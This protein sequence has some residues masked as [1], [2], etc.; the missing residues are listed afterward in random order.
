M[1]KNQ[2]Y[3]ANYK[4]GFSKKISVAAKFLAFLGLFVGALY[5]NNLAAQITVVNSQTA[6]GTNNVVITRPT[7]LQV[8]DLM[9]VNLQYTPNNTLT[10]PSGWTERV[11]YEGGSGSTRARI[12]YKVAI[13]ADV[14]ATNYTFSV[15]SGVRIAGG[16]SA[17]RGVNTA[18]DGG[19]NVLGTEVFANNSTTTIQPPA[20]T[21]TAANSMVLFFSQLR[22]QNLS[23]NADWK[24]GGASGTA[25]NQLYVQ[26]A[27]NNTDGCGVSGAFFIRP[28]TGSTGA[29][30]QTTASGDGRRAGILMALT[31]IPASSALAGVSIPSNSFCA[32]TTKQPLHAFSLAQTVGNG[33][34]SEVSFSTTGTYL[35][36][37]VVNFKLWTNTT[38]NLTSAVQ[39][40]STLTTSLGSGTHTFSGFTQTLTVNDTRFFWITTDA[41]FPTSNKTIGVSAITTANLTI[42]GSKT[43][44]P[45]TATSRTLNSTAIISGAISPVTIPGGNNGAIDVSLTG[46][47][48]SFSYSWSNGAASQD[49]S[50]LT[51]GNY[52]LTLT[53]GNNCAIARTFIVGTNLV[54][55]QLYLSDPSQSLD[56]VSPINTF[57]NTTASSSVFSTISSGSVTITSSKVSQNYQSQP[58]RNFGNTTVA[59]VEAENN[60][61]SRTFIQFDLSNIPSGATITSAQLKLVHTNVASCDNFVGSGAAFTTNVQRVTREWDE[62]DQ[63]NATT[64]N[65]LSWNTAGSTNWSDPGGDFHPT[66][67]ASWVGGNADAEGTEY[68]M[69]ITT[70]VNEWRN[71]THPNY[72]L[73]LVS[74]S[75]GAGGRWYNIFADEASVEANRPQL[76]VSY[77]LPSST[78]TSFTQS[79]ALASPLTIKAGNPISITNYVTVTG[80]SM[81]SNPSITAT[82]RYGSTTIATLTNPTYNSSTG[83]LT[84]TTTL[85]SDVTVPA[86]QAISLDITTAQSG[87]AFII[88][89]DSQAKPSLIDLPVSSY[90]NI[91]SLD[92]YNAANPGGS[93]ITSANGASTVYLRSNVTDPFGFADITGMDISIT[94]PGGA[95]SSVTGTS[96]AGSGAN[97]TYEY[98]WTT[99]TIGGA[100]TI[101]AIAKE[102]F[103]NSVIA[104]RQTIFNICDP[105]LGGNVSTQT[106]ILC[107]G[108]SSGSFT[109]TGS[110]GTPPYQYSLNS[111]AF[112]TTNTFTGRPAGSYTVA[113]RDANN[114]TSSS[115][116]NITLS[117]PAAAVTVTPSIT[118]PT[119][120]AFG[121]I[122]LVAAGGTAPY[123]YD[124]AD[125]SGT[126]NP[127][128]RTGLAAG[129][130]TVVV[131][132]A[133]GCTVSSGSITLDP[134]VGCAPITI[135]TNSSS[136]SVFSVDPDPS[137]TNYTWTITPA[138][139]V[140]TGQGT[141]QI[142]VN[143]SGVTTAG[144]FQVCV[145]AA[146]ACGTTA[147]LCQNVNVVLPPVPVVSAGPAC[148]GQN[149]QLLASGG[150]SYVWSGPGGFASSVANPI[151]AN[152]S[153]SNNGT[154]SVLIT[155]AAGCSATGTV[156]VTV[157][158]PPVLSAAVTNSTACASTSGAVNLTVTP[159]GTYSYVWNNGASNFS[160]N[161]DVTGLV[162]GNYHVLVTNTTSGCTAPA[163]Y[164]V[165]AVPGPMPTGIPVNIACFGTNAGAI[166]SIG[167]MGGTA[168]YAFSWT[169]PNGFTSASTGTSLTGLAAGTYNLTVIDNSGCTGFFTTTI[170]QASAINI[171]FSQTNVSCFGQATGSISVGAAGGTG[172]YSYGWLRNGS[173]FGTN[174]ATLGSL[175][176][177][178]YQVTVSDGNGCTASQIIEITQPAAA[179]GAVT[180][181]TNVGCFGGTNGQVVLSPT[182]GTAPY[183]F[184]WTGPSGFTAASKDI[185]GRAAGTY[186]V[187]ITDARGCTFVVSGIIITQSSAITLATVT[188]TPVSC[189]GGSNGVIEVLPSGGTAPFGYQWS[190]G[191][192]TAR[193]TGLLAGS[194]TVTVTDA[195]G[196]QPAFA[197]AIVVGQPAAAL[198]VTATPAAVSCFGGTNGGVTTVV[199]GGTTD[200]AYFWSNN[201]ATP[202][203]SNVVAGNYQVTV[204]DN[205][206]CTAIATATVGSPADI[207][208]S[209]VITDVLCNGATTGTITLSVTGGTPNFSYNWG[210]GIM[211]Q[212][213]TDLGAGTYEVTVT[214]GNG[215]T[216]TKAYTITEASLLAAS[217][218]NTNISCNGGSNGA[219]NLSVSGGVGPYTYL[220]SNGANTEDLIGLAAGP[221]SVTVT[222]ANNCSAVF[223]APDVI[224][225]AV[226]TLSVVADKATDCFGGTDGGATATPTGGTA[227][228]TYQWSDGGS[229]AARIDL[230][231]GDYTVTVTDV[232][233]CTAQNTVIISQPTELE[234]F[235]EV[236][237]NNGC[238]Q[239][240]SGAIVLTVQGGT[241]A[242]SY[243]WSRTGGGFSSSF[244]DISGLSAGTYTVTVTDGNGCARQLTSVVGTEVSTLSASISKTDIT[245]LGFPNNTNGT[246]SVVAINGTLPYAYDWTGTPIGDGTASISSLAAGTY[247]VTI[248]DAGGCTFTTSVTVDNSV[249][250]VL[251][252]AVDDVLSRCSG[253]AITGTVAT[254]DNINGLPLSQ[255]TFINRGVPSQSQGE[256]EWSNTF[257]GSYIFTPNPTFS[258]TVTIPYTVEDQFGLSAT[259]NLIITISRLDLSLAAA[260][261]VDATCSTQGSITIPEPT[262][263]T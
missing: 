91:A 89:Y 122:S 17:F 241:T 187:T 242:Y 205:N 14:S 96:V 108:Q 263:G 97:R 36:N 154:Y 245:C 203:L 236:T 70:L 251:P 186:E 24:L 124:W 152:A 110:G 67:Y 127:M 6:V 11:T 8:G 27:P 216:D 143:W 90:I 113:V 49:I 130:Y 54:Y 160:T 195:F 5:N 86:G 174:S 38:N 81:P 42:S 173:P 16:I 136:P 74:P 149:V 69:N 85:G 57:D 243:A 82:L 37:E 202:N 22:L 44:G 65:S 191:G 7:G 106:N 262:S 161:E 87:V 55:K 224:H 166:N 29:G 237:N 177:A 189:F 209:A 104:S 226:L 43:G 129:T 15:A 134:P 192:N 179:L 156:S 167:V 31:P 132:D 188:N 64:T 98:A 71:L 171:N 111:G 252:V 211:L 150:S 34:L 56:R 50:N 218:V 12:A 142:S 194:Y 126:N 121:S 240:A 115:T 248:T 80:G 180:S 165:N 101:N 204:T 78:T 159:A 168:P 117:Q 232:N 198:T 208:L 84:W 234:L 51:A 2:L 176:A 19:I 207:E 102:G 112:S 250:C 178:T 75:L 94:A 1:K 231:A 220:W 62:G 95:V 61:L 157:T 200:Y 181:I 228:Y 83:T 28:T 219:I 175:T 141:N 199:S 227:P 260:T 135:C 45:T 33:S 162:Q 25:M 169:G 146:N 41:G 246:A 53:D 76:I 196:C 119:C 133:N 148:M 151:L 21:T 193:I 58:T 114:C 88:D 140:I 118:Q 32:G 229:G 172:T 3:T 185:S 48:P 256:L 40:G 258:G 223:T 66:I 210:G 233:G 116:V 261:V 182:G 10:Y 190:N 23:F 39:L 239:S 249:A 147:S 144:V 72:G 206:G 103:E 30:Y 183:T 254:N 73:G 255:M 105:A 244:K 63:C 125:V 213:R 137:I 145:A 131:T 238:G 77:T 18:T 164:S 230:A 52:T 20:I 26:N 214:D 215:C 60:F 170:T 68:L 212:N 79:P 109:V 92:F 9:I 201:A 163:T 123:T 155:N 59:R 35:A 247:S 47:T 153:S 100:Y 217:F 184:A 138:G 253:D 225:P 120:L 46:G 235:A 158:S 139:A 197:P 99:P 259:G 107:F 13:A 222:D 93:I 4:A 221:Y 128:N 257:N